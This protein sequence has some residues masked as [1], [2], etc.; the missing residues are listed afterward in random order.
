MPSCT[1]FAVCSSLLLAPPNLKL[2]LR[3][4]KPSESRGSRSRFRTRSA[5]KQPT[6]NIVAKK[7]VRQEDVDS[8]YL[9]GNRLERPAFAGAALVAS[10]ATRTVTVASRDARAAGAQGDD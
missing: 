5:P 4:V 8:D 9:F 2:R 6:R 1:C 7:R 3:S 10:S